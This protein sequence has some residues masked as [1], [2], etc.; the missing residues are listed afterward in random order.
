MVEQ[1]INFYRYKTQHR[2][3][4]ENNLETI[5]IAQHYEISPQQGTIYF[6]IALICAQARIILYIRSDSYSIFISSWSSAKYLLSYSAPRKSYNSYYISPPTDSWSGQ[7][8]FIFRPRYRLKHKLFYI[9]L[10]IHIL[11]SS[12]HG[13]RRDTYY[14]IQ[15]RGEL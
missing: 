8:S 6:I 9:S 15:L 14:H 13:T 5:I 2:R 1:D 12:Q 7:F 3:I 10:G 4:L 11:Y